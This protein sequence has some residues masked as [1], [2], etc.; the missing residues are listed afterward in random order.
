M[1]I[2]QKTRQSFSK[3]STEMQ[4]FKLSLNFPLYA[5]F[6]KHVFQILNRQW[7]NRLEESVENTRQSRQTA[8]DHVHQQLWMQSPYAELTESFMQVLVK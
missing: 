8:R 2:P 5:F 3:K 1:E 4:N 7:L 6:Q